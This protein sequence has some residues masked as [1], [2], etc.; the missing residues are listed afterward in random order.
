MN[1]YLET[2]RMRAKAGDEDAAVQLDLQQAAITQQNQRSIQFAEQN[3][4]HWEM[5]NGMVTT[6][7]VPLNQPQLRHPK[8]WT[9][10]TSIEALPTLDRVFCAD[11]YYFTVESNFVL[12]GDHVRV[13]RGRVEIREQQN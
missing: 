5:R 11:N 4:W 1:E 9:E 3:G 6:S 7:N 2:L 13:R 10:V 8:N 12:V